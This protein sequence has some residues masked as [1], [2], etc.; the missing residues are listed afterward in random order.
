MKSSAKLRNEV[1]P[2]TVLLT[3]WSMSGEAPSQKS[4]KKDEVILYSASTATLLA[5][6]SFEALSTKALCSSARC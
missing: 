2:G 4:H 5:V 3:G 1:E 6:S